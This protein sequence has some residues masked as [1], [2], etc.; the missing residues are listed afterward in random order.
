MRVLTA[1]IAFVFLPVFVLGAELTV[2]VSIPP[3]KYLLERI[4]G[5]RVVVNVMMGS[6]SD[7]HSF[8][9]KIQQAVLL[10]KSALYIGIGFPFEAS[11]LKQLASSYKNLEIID[12]SADLDKVAENGHGHKHGEELD[13]H[14]WTSP[15]LMVKVAENT[16]NALIK[17]DPEG[18][19]RYKSGYESFKAEALAFDER[20]KALFKGE[21]IAF[22]VYHPSFG[23]FAADYGL[24]QHSIEVDGASPKALQ[25]KAFIDDAREEGIKL[26][27]VQPTHSDAAA[28]V[29]A[30]ELNLNTVSI[31]IL[32]ED[33]GAMMEGLYQA[34]AAL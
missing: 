22:L 12:S 9:P 18:C 24:H 20:F 21:E 25:I 6:G 19:Q 30:K 26:F 27:I 13:P 5:E 1:V 10:S 14:V 16:M 2:T 32:A 3:Q 17:A 23:Y 34:F 28:G 33:W 7:P 15:R 8:S 11:T 29:I 31:D 4:A